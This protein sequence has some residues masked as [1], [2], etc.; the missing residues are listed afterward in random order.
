MTY[1]GALGLGLL[2]HHATRDRLPASPAAGIATSAVLIAA[3]PASVAIVALG[4]TLAIL[5]VRRVRSGSASLRLGLDHLGQVL[6]VALSAGLPVA[7]ALEFAVDEVGPVEAAEVR[8]VLRTAR[9]QGLA[10]ALTGADGASG[11]LFA[12]LARAQL[13]GSSAIKAVGSFVDEERNIR[14][15]RAAEAAQRLPVKLTVPLALLILPGFILLTIGPTV[16][17]TVQRLFGPLLA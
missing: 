13:T 5:R 1:L 2:V 7:A 3:A 15:A 17:A 10:V 8:S 12:L 9:H 4:W 14:R 16:V 6:Y 11:R